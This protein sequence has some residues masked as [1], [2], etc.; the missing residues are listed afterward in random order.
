LGSKDALSRGCYGFWEWWCGIEKVAAISQSPLCFICTTISL[1]L[2]LCKT[3]L[4]WTFYS[5]CFFW[6]AGVFLKGEEEEDN[7]LCA[8]I[9][10][11]CQEGKRRH[12]K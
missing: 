7:G 4:F 5:L 2:L 6:S 3:C 12:K 8:D 10:W 11:L 9:G 1:E